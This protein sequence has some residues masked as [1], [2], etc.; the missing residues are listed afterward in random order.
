MRTRWVLIGVAGLAVLATGGCKKMAA[1]E[2]TPAEWFGLS[3]QAHGRY[4]GVGVYTPG[5]AWSKMVTAGRPKDSA[6]AQPSDDGAVIVMVDSVTGEVRGCGD[7]T[8]YCVGMN[9][10]KSPLAP[11]QIAPVPLNRAADAES[12]APA[13]PA[14]RG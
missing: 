11:G 8:G 4:A 7:M 12:S 6:V 14:E 1:A 10:W 5:A 3:S 9:P 2:A 13:T